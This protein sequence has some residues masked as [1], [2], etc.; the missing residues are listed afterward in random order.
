MRIGDLV[1]KIKG[2]GKGDIG[3]VIKIERAITTGHMLHVFVQGEIIKW[4]SGYVEKLCR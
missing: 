2:K 3:I 1:T 4:Y